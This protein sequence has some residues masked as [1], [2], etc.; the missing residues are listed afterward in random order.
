M[1]QFPARYK[2]RFCL[3]NEETAV[4]IIR[5][6]TFFKATSAADSV[7]TSEANKNVKNKHAKTAEQTK[8]NSIFLHKIIIID[9]IYQQSND[10]EENSV[11]KIQNGHKIF[12]DARK[13][14]KSR[15]ISDKS[16]Y[17]H[18]K[19]SNHYVNSVGE[20][21]NNS[22]YSIKNTATKQIHLVSPKF[23]CVLS[24]L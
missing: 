4:T 13:K 10:Y 22:F 18:F 7:D 14:R 8:E 2:Q 11:K 3:K 1:Q 16:S 20:N 24:I 12:E 5:V 21:C 19:I 17:S 23:S 6:S 9:I 15:V